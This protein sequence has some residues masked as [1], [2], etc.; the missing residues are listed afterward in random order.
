MTRPLYQNVAGESMEK[1][2]TLAITSGFFVEGEPKPKGSL[3]PV[4]RRGHKVRMIEDIAG[5]SGWR[6]RMAEAFASAHGNRPTITGGVFTIT[7]FILPKFRTS[8]R[9][10]PILRSDYDIDK[11]ARNVN[12]ALV[13]A[14]V[15]EDDSRIVWSAQGKLYPLHSTDP[16]GVY[17]CILPMDSD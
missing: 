5:S 14:R 13:D 7:L 11:L 16:T 6:A 8:K 15:L 4:G 17:V 2:L 12:D 1:L 3:R 10:W 9:V